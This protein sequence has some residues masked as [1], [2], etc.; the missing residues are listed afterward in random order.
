MDGTSRRPPMPLYDNF[1]VEIN[2]K[3]CAIPPD[4]RARLQ[5]SLTGLADAVRDL[6]NSALRIDVIHHSQKETYHAEFTLT[7]PGR[8]IR[9]GE[10]DPYLDTALQ[11]CV[12]KM[13][14]KAEE[15]KEHPDREALAAAERR[16]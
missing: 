16:Q 3:E 14:L 4:E 7:L 6:P 10:E 1:N 11:R 15:Y 12:R 8:T 2:A 13:I 5:T 9:T